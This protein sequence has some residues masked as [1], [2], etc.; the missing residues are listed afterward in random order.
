MYL[1]LCLLT[2][3]SL[4]A[5]AKSSSSKAKAPVKAASAKKKAAKSPSRT[6]S[7]TERPTAL[8]SRSLSFNG[9]R[10]IAPDALQK[11]LF[12]ESGIVLPDEF[13]SSYKGILIQK[14]ARRLTLFKNGRAAKT[15]MATIGRN[16]DEAK[17]RAGDWATPVGFYYVRRKNPASKYYL[18]LHISYPNND[19][20]ARG[21]SD[22]LISESQ[23]SAIVDA[24]NRGIMPPQNT[25]LGYYI[26][27]HGGSNR[28]IQDEEG[29]DRLAGWTRGCVGLRN[30]DIREIYNWAPEGTP[31]Y[32]LP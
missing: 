5:N 28:I 30:R 20:A 17:E 18:A 15:Y 29:Q 8:S 24:N 26:E 4:V 2:T 14:S 19:D 23:Y 31:V 22:G 11:A 3:G 21:L 32:I 27:I 25:P 13:L 1:S 9:G 12:E 10:R 6:G 16:E 7:R